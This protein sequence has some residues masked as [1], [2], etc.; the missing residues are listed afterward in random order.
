MQTEQLRQAPGAVQKQR[1][2]VLSGAAFVAAP[3][4]AHQVS[5]LGF[6]HP[7]RLPTPDVVA[8]ELIHLRQMRAFTRR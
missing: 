3:E 8:Q 2:S 7:H 1:L 4:I 6:V 5:K